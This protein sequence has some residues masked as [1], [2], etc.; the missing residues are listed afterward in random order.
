MECV[1]EA[2]KEEEGGGKRESSSGEEGVIVDCLVFPEIASERDKRKKEKSE[3]EK[4][5]F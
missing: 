1:R 2:G 3:A 5:G 4:S